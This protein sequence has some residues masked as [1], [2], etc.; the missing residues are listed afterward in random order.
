M[1]KIQVGQKNPKTV[2]MGG[3]TIAPKGTTVTNNG[4]SAEEKAKQVEEIVRLPQEQIVPELRKHGFNDITDITEVQ[5]KQERE[6]AENLA[7]S[8]ANRLAEIKSLPD[9]EQLPLLLE[10]GFTEEA[11][12]LSERLAASQQEKIDDGTIDEN[13]GTEAPADGTSHELN[14]AAGARAG[15]AAGGEEAEKEKPGRPK[16]SDNE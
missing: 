11:Q 4:V 9:D 3:F 13:T 1:G 6:K 5:M 15:T 16:K 12:E 2:D 14:D 10:E 8:R 7:A